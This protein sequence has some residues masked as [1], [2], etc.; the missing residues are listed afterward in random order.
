[1]E[2]Q[3]FVKNLS[4]S[5]AF[6]KSIHPNG[7]RATSQE[8]GTRWE[9]YLVQRVEFLECNLAKCIWALEKEELTTFISQIETPD[10]RVWLTEV[11]AMLKHEELTQVVVCLWAI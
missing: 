4:F 8:H 6:C 1:M 5:M 2:N 10:A 11:M 3:S 7:R 9:L